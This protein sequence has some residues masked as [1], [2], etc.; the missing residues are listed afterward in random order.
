MDKTKPNRAYLTVL[1]ITACCSVMCFIDG[2]VV[3]PYFVKSAFKL[4]LFLLVPLAYFAVTKTDKQT[5]CSLFV[6][7]KKDFILALALGA[8][9]YA[10]IVGGYFIFRNVFDFSA[11]TNQL[12]SGVGVGTDNFL[13]IAI[14][15]SLVNSLLEEFFFRGFAFLTLKNQ[16]PKWLAYVFS[17]ALFAFYH[18][19]MTAGWFS[20]IMYILAMAGL[21]V[22]GCIFNFLNERCGNI[23]PS[24]LVHMF[25]NF[26]INTIGFILFGMI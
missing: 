17:S 25:A 13:F 22:G 10:V 19:G 18:M 5:L 4:A 2:V 3:P 9:V 21:S 24:W 20:P 23:Y 7:H 8:S 12:T 11:I 15:I 6:P 14:Y 26:G 16:L 1:I